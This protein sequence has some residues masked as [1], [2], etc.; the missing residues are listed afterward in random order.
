MRPELEVGYADLGLDLRP[1]TVGCVADSTG[2]E[3][4]DARVAAL[5]RVLPIADPLVR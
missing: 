5:E 1:E 4:R 3:V 2:Q